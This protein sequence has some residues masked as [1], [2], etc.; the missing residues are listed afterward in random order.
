MSSIG[1]NQG[2][3]LKISNDSLELI[4]GVGIDETQRFTNGRISIL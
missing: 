1:F 4:L 3:S 2:F